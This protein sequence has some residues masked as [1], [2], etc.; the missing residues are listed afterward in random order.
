MTENLIE[1]ELL[2][3]F[4]AAKEAKDSADKDLKNAK[5]IYS[6]WEAQLI[7]HLESI[8]ATATAKYEG[9]GA[10]SMPAP[11]LYANCL[12]ENEG[13]LFAFLREQ[14][15]GDMIKTS[16]A[17]VGLSA[18]AKEFIAEGGELP[19]IITT[20]FKTSIKLNK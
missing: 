10:A 18:F 2:I 12:K 19:E 20:Y 8:E 7:D 17:A 3:N 4:K 1:K 16:V 9:I 5:A 13:E 14:E 6:K 11:R 15:R